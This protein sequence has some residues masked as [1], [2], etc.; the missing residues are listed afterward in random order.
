MDSLNSQLSTLNSQLSTF[1]SQLS[2]LIPIFLFNFAMM[3]QKEQEKSA[4][5]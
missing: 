2:T 3:V 1:N 4:N 5:Q